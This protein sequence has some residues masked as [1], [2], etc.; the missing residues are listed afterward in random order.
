MLKSVISRIK[1]FLFVSQRIINRQEL[2][3]YVNS[4][5]VVRAKITSAAFIL[6]E[7]IFLFLALAARM[8]HPPRGSS[9]CYLWMYVIMLSAMIVFLIIF[10]RFGKNIS[11]HRRGIQTAGFFFIVFILCWCA[12]I[13]LLDQLHSGQIMVYAFAL[14]AVSVTPIVAPLPMLFILLPIQ[15]AFVVF[16]IWLAPFSGIPVGNIFN[17]SAFTV[18]AWASSLMRYKW[19]LWG[20]QNEKLIQEKNLELNRINAQLR[21]ANQKLEQLS[22]TDSLTGISNRSMF[23]FMIQSEWD[24]CKRQQ[25]PLSLIMA[26]I[27]L[28]K[29]YNDHYGHQAGDCCIRQVAT[30]LSSCAKRAS[31]T[32]ARYGGEEFAVILPGIT[33]RQAGQIAE[34]MRQRV[35]N[36]AIPHVIFSSLNRVT[37]SFGVDTVLPGGENL[38]I[39]ALIGA[40]DRALYEAKL[41]RN[42][43]V[44]SKEHHMAAE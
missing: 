23:D 25:L 3:D 4:I 24:R 8:Q 38:T 43:V 1:A 36:L 21:E 41:L 14:I 10:N 28:F 6:L 33:L 18:I 40:A 39:A 27:D 15:T 34:Q 13:S 5:N 9:E 7:G 29:N 26:D 44:L 11:A 42:Q 22:R 30:V 32:V 20:F 17:S 2:A 16:S 19:H 31:D 12:G 35:E 37:V